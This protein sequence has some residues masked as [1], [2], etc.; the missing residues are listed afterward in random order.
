MEPLGMVLGRRG[1]RG[2]DSWSY[3]PSE[4]REGAPGERADPPGEQPQG[5]APARVARSSNTQ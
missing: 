3:L 4:A 5:R 2:R 1:I